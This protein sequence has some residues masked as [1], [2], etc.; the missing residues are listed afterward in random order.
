MTSVAVPSVLDTSL[1]LQDL[2]LKKKESVLHE[3]VC[4]AQGVRVVRDAD[5]LHDTLVRR[6]RWCSSAIGKG[7]AVPH[8]R[9][10]GVLIP[11]TIVGRSL[12]GV[13]WGAADGLA[14]QLVLLVLSPSE[15]SPDVHLDLVARAIAITRLQRNR[16][17]LLD[18]D[19]AAAL[20]DVLREAGA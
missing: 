17:R 4:A 6:E 15:S 13:D 19:G 14:V 10:L 2:K 20:A 1:F 9:S 16:Q 8:A 7:V 5:L 11:R 18:A 3:L 12:R